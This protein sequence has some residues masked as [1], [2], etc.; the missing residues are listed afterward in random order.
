M[1]GT[2][3][4]AGP[5]S[6]LGR[7][8]AGRR[9]A[10]RRPRSRRYAVAV[11]D[12][13]VMPSASTRR[14]A[15]RGKLVDA[16]DLVP[17]AHTPGHASGQRT[18]EAGGAYGRRARPLSSPACGRVAR[19]AAPA[20][21]SGPHARGRARQRGRRIRGAD[22]SG[23]DAA[24]V[25]QR[26]DARHMPATPAAT[27]GAEGDRDASPAPAGTASPTSSVSASPLAAHPVVAY[28]DPAQRAARPSRARSRATFRTRCS[29]SRGSASAPRA[30]LGRRRARAAC[31][32]RR[33]RHAAGRLSR[34]PRVDVAVVAGAGVRT[35][36]LPSTVS[37]R[38]RWRSPAR[39]QRPS[40][41]PPMLPAP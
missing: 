8:R 23:T 20:S 4:R 11:D 21:H 12:D 24:D 9:R 28:C 17:L 13:T 33:S 41:P 25:R 37:R 10:S 35:L 34:S 31:A 3:D 6:R 19:C 1:A 26:G 15:A 18:R 30:G 7:R 38:P 39:P 22:R 5:R 14:R 27:N 16:T 36:R 32:R 2:L 40:S 29:T